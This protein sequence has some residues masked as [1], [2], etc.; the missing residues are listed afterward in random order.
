M[1]P[2]VQSSSDYEGLTDP[3]TLPLMRRFFALSLLATI[4]CGAT[5]TPS[6]RAA[7]AEPATSGR[8]VASARLG[9]RT[10]LRLA[11]GERPLV[12]VV[13]DPGR[14]AD[15]HAI[16]DV[17]AQLLELAGPDVEVVHTPRRVPVL[18]ARMDRAAVLRVLSDPRARRVDMDVGGSGGL[19]EALPLSGFDV[20][21]AAGFDGTGTV[22]A[23]VD[24]GF[25]RDHRDL[26]EALIDEACFCVPWCCPNGGSVQLTAGAAE[27][28]HWHGTFVSGIITSDG[29]DA[30]V[31]AT[32][33]AKIVAVKILD[34]QNRFF[35]TLQIVDAL[36]WLVD[37]EQPIQAVNLSLGTD[38]LFAGE[39][40]T[41]TAWTVALFEAVEAL[42]DLGVTVV[43][44]SNNDGATNEMAAPACLSN[45]IAVGSYIDAGSSL[46]APAS[47]SNVS[48]TLDLYAPGAVIASTG[49]GGGTRRGSGTSFAAPQV[50]AC[51]AVLHAERP[52]PPAEVRALL[53]QGPRRI[54]D[55]LGRSF[56][57][58]DCSAVIAD[59]DIDTDGI[60]TVD[61]N[62]PTVANPDQADTDGDGEGDACEVDEG[63]NGGCACVAAGRWSSVG[64]TAGICVLLGLI[65]RMVTTRRRR[66]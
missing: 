4:G 33:G 41:A 25:D 56:P 43:A 11:Q 38:A 28:D 8:S 54:E 16:A 31:G 9:Q 23:V 55:P 6:H 19:A 5:E 63:S 46:G 59:G 49:R 34:D 3:G 42:N 27:D 37:T 24:S 61:D 17:R 21:L 10:A 44:S 2:T 47:N 65:G 20:L 50:A 51:A 22:V 18:G 62:C 15:P 13:F 45:V 48:E 57:A 29:L 14:A 39:C 58:L 1:V 36:D 35:S 7:S 52:R 30:P 66:S 32:P 60:A 53:K 12:A 26:Q 40:D 64:R